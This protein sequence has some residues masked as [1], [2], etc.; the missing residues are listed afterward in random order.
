MKLS[1]MKVT[2][3]LKNFGSCSNLANFLSSMILITF[4]TQQSIAKFS[5]TEP[6]KWCKHFP[7]ASASSLSR[8]I[9]RFLS[10]AIIA[11]PTR[12][13]I[14]DLCEQT[15]IRGFT[16]INT[17]LGFDS[18]LLLPKNSDGKFRTK[19]KF[20]NYKIGNEDKRVLSKYWKWTKK[21]KNSGTQWQ[22]LCQPA[23]SKEKKTLPWENLTW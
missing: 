12:T 14:V 13:E 21:K 20:E 11:I 15:F 19:R 3:A 4:R 5:K 1:M 16:C 17:R 7:G 9:H 18:K 10:K 6:S 22:N 8:Y 23:A 2:K